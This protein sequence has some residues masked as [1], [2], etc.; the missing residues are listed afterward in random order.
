MIGIEINE[1]FLDLSSDTA[2]R[3]ELNSTA[4]FGQD[5]NILP[6]SFTFPITVGKTTANKTALGNVFS[7][8]DPSNN[9][10][11]E[12]ARIYLGGVLCFRG[13]AQLKDI[14]SISAKLTIYITDFIDIKDRPINEFDY[15]GVRELGTTY[16]EKTDHMIDTALNPDNYDYIFFPIYNPDYVSEDAGA[17]D[18]RNWQNPNGYIEDPHSGA[19]MPFVKLDYAVRRI[20]AASNF[21][22]NIDVDEADWN[23]ICLYNNYSIYAEENKWANEFNLK[24]HVGNT[25][26]GDFLKK[27]FRLFN[28][29]LDYN[30]ISRTVDIF[31]A[32]KNLTAEEVNWTDRALDN[33]VKK[34]VTETYRS[35]EYEPN[36]S[37]EGLNSRIL[38]E[39]PYPFQDYVDQVSDIPTPS[40][41]DS[42]KAWY[43]RSKDWIYISHYFFNAPNIFPLPI[44]INFVKSVGEGTRFTSR[45]RCLRNYVNE[46]VHGDITWP[47]IS[48]AGTIPYRDKTAD[49]PDS[50]TIFRGVFDVTDF[51]GAA[52]ANHH[53]Y[54]PDGNEIG[55]LS[56]SWVADK[57]LWNTYWKPWAYM[58]YDRKEVDWRL[59][60]SLNDIINFSFRR[61]YRLDNQNYLCKKLELNVTMQGLEEAVA[62]MVSIKS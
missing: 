5:T 21:S 19:T 54:D 39:Y 32:I 62:T 22:V 26:A 53:N 3:I 15:G 16:T 37:E 24:N 44:G 49:F 42:F 13:R 18:W 30:W 60:L 29:Q 43:V 46:E 31:P 56:L 48:Q 45:I 51:F 35:W 59:D 61:R 47:T 23:R 10:W 11:Y 33:P 38:E 7:L 12:D 9:Y 25:K 2:L 58:L 1:T 6:G 55:D 40:P 14:S 17:E 36:T 50:I 41:G 57:G 28:L 27:F 52:Y 4:Y 34:E 8:D 20:L